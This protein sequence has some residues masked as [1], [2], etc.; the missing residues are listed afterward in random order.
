MNC[1]V[2]LEY[3]FFFH[4]GHSLQTVYERSALLFHNTLPDRLRL[5]NLT[6]LFS[7]LGFSIAT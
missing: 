4:S 3:F 5:A 1:G 7:A 6:S 2:L